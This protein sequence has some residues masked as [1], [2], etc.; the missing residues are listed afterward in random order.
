MEERYT[1]KKPASIK[2]RKRVGRGM[3]SG[4]GKTS[5]RGHKGQMSRSGAKR[6]AWFEG[7]QMPLQRRVPKRGFNNLFRLEF[8]VVN[9][10]ELGKIDAAEIDRELLQKRGLVKGKNSAIKILGNGSIDKAM[11]VY[12]DAFSATAR[13]KIEKA[14]GK[15]IV[16]QPAAQKQES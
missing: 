14:G 3:S 2:S 15:A 10:T 4:H 8:V 12:A 1:L 13:E 5:C 6:R 11:T 16:G 7:G 9:L